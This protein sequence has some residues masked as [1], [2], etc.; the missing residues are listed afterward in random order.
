MNASCTIISL[1]FALFYPNVGTVLSYFGAASGFLIIYCLPVFV[2][3]KHKK[4]QMQNPILAEALQKNSYHF[5]SRNTL[6]SPKIIVN[7]DLIKSRSHY[8]SKKP[9][10]LRYNIYYCLHMMIPLY[11]LATVVF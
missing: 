3:L 2:H 1:L 5:E 9:S 7:D 6:A 8:N 10:M 11:G 4:T